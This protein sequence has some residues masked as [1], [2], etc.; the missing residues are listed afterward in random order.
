MAVSTDPTATP[1]AV[2]LELL[3][4]E[5][6]SWL[7]ER[8]LGYASLHGYTACTSTLVESWRVSVA[9]L[10]EAIA[11]ALHEPGPRHEY[12]M[13]PSAPHDA[14]AAFA[15]LEAKRH[16]KRGVT[17][18]MFW[19]LLKYY[20]RAY[21]DLLDEPLSP[22][23]DREAA[24]T[25][26]AECFERM[27]FS[28]VLQWTALSGK[29]ANAALAEQNLRLTNEKTKYLTVF[30]SVP[31]AL[32]LLDA[33][34]RVENANAAALAMLGFDAPT[35]T[36]Y[37]AQAPGKDASGE[38]SVG[39]QPLADLLPWLAQSLRDI[40]AEGVERVIMETTVGDG[41][42]KRYYSAA[43]G[44]LRDVT[45]NLTGKIVLCRDDTLQRQAR[46]ALAKSEERYRILADLMHQGLVIL[47]SD[48]HIDFAN[49]AIEVLLGHPLG[50]IVGQP[51]TRF[52]RPQDHDTFKASLDRRQ[53]GEAD[54][55]EMG[56][57][58]GDGSVVF[59][60]SSPSV[61]IGE[62]NDYQ[63][64]LE[65]FTDITH[66]KKLEVQLATAKRLEA[67]GQLAGGVAHEI[68]TPLQYVSGNLD[69][70]L[71]NLPRLIELLGKYEQALTT[72]T[73][74]QAF[75]TVKSDIETFRAKHDMD[76]ILAE[77]PLALDE[78][79]HGTERVA[80]FV[81][82][83]KR[84]A[85]SD[86]VGRRAIDV[87]EAIQATVE[88]A[89]STQEIPICVEMD[90]A[91]DVPALPC[92]PG[93][94]NQLLLC[95]LI[96]A[97]QAM[98]RAG[99]PQGCVRVSSRQEGNHVAL[100]VS[101]VGTGIPPDLQDRIFS[102]FITGKDGGQGLSIVLSIVEKHK[103]AIRCISQPGHG[104]TFHVTFPLDA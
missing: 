71:A 8:V 85:Q 82:S 28:F 58:R 96:N 48:G 84:F 92:V 99:R 44:R 11:T 81:R 100:A 9:G 15:I 12:P 52:I 26:L 27:E 83:I 103:G 1:P 63:G 78:S 5:R 19:G 38:Q 50:E 40:G 3:L 67:I 77:L 98:E 60:M 14:I 23:Q 91:E 87:N 57:V 56:L 61:V 47:S 37:Y 21:L 31:Q 25:F 54:P 69:F 10:T 90:L 17:L 29:E 35:G 33:D 49:L 51:L 93:D 80:S 39:G 32:F 68:N 34:G 16:R 45:G 73:D 79:L 101:D 97:S 102:P 70:A 74:S 55:Y 64:S 7:M 42:G 86:G 94:F 76:T 46:Q 24:K 89:K 18:A 59:I 6:E 43:I 4:R 66:L 62:D 104:A 22:E 95:L 65:V 41:E 20:R 36:L 2:W 88:V 53:H 13:K 75:E 72:P 30:E